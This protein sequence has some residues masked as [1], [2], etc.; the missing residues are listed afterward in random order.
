MQLKGEIKLTE[1]QQKAA[2]RVRKEFLEC[3][4]APETDV[5]PPTEEMMMMPDGQALRTIIYR[6]KKSVP[7]PV[8]IMR[9]CYPEN[10]GVYRAMAE[11]Y[12]KRGF[13]FVYQYCRG[14]GGSEGIWEP[15]VNERADGSEMLQRICSRPWVKNAGYLGCSY[16]ALTGW[17]VADILPEKVK[18]MYLTHYGTFRH[19]SAYMDGLFRHDVLTSWAMDNAGFNV[20]ADYIKSCRHMP[21]AET[22][23]K[24]WGQ[25]LE[26][27]RQ[28]IASPDRNSA[29]WN[30]GFW[31]ILK[32]IPGKVKVPV[33]IGEGWYDHH[34]GSAIET[35]KALS[36]ECREKSRFFIG[37]WE[38]GF[39]LKLEGHTDGKKF[40]NNDNVRAFEWFYR[41]LVKNETPKGQI[42][43]YIIGHNRWYSREKYDIDSQKNLKLYL[44]KSAGNNS[45]Q[46][47]NG[48]KCFGAEAGK[49]SGFGQKNVMGLYREKPE[50]AQ[51][52]VYV[53]EPENPV[54]THGAES[55]LKTNQEQGSLLQPPAGYRDDVISFIS[56]PFDKEVTVLGKIKVNLEVSSDAEDT[57]FA[58]K[59]MEVM[60]DGRAYNMRTGITTLAYLGGRDERTVYSPGQKVTAVIDMWDLAWK[61]QKGS[62]LRIDV[63]SSDFPQ[64]AVHSNFAGIWSEQ[65][66]N[67]KA[68]QTIYFGGENASCIKLPLLTAEDGLNSV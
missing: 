36:E 59:V 52:A 48:K 39:N 67:K 63:T 20:S 5:S 47:C 60:P 53:Y 30:S 25:R 64:Y 7:V 17:V 58:V 19:T 32:S 50:T 12:C 65:E 11:E 68:V 3:A 43:T 1:Q 55:L 42:D 54:I 21:H 16:L 23:E 61:I 24:L 22:D 41:I 44:G 27:Y 33:C 51:K 26:W 10:D 8:I 31:G 56:E 9:T 6:P 46:N 66:R 40:K 49:L 29:Y 28:W 35:Y 37:A 15:N 14:T 62:R 57:A 18:T 34:L 45:E 38:H 4:Y 2:D 13:A